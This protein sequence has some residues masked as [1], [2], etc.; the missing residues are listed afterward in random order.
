[1]FVST[2]RR[3]PL[4]MIALLVLVACGTNK[5]TI[6][7]RVIDAYTN[8]P[9]KDAALTF[10]KNGPVKTDAEGRYTTTAWSAKESVSIEAP[11]YETTSINLAEKPELAKTEP[12]TATLD[13]TIR[14]N[15]LRGVVKDAYTDQPVANAL[16]QATETISAT[17]DANGAYTLQSLPETFQIAV[18]APDYVETR[19]DISR[20]TTHELTLR[21]SV[22]RGIV[23]DT[24]SGQPVTGA[25]V[26]AGDISATTGSDG[27]YELKDVRE[28]AEVVFTADGYDE[29]KQ[30]MPQATSLDVA[31]RPNVI[32]G[33]VVDS[34]DGKPLA[35]ATVIATPTITGT[36]VAVTRTDAKGNYKLEDVPEGAYIRALLPGYRRGETQVKEG[37]LSPEIKLERFE[38]KA[39]YLKAN[40]ASN[41]METVNEYYDIIDQTELNSIVID[42]KSDNLADVGFIYYQSQV[43]EVL[44]AE[45]SADYMPI[46]E[47]LAE[48]KK[49][50]IYTI[51]RVHIFAHDNALLEKHPDWYVQKDGKPWFADF[52]IAWL[53]TYDE[54]VWDYNIKL[55]V[56][57][58][59]LGFDEIQFDYIRFPSDGDL[60]GAKFKGPRDWKNNPDEMFNTIGRF[61]ERAQKAINGAGAY[62]SVDVFGY[63]AWKPQANIGQNLQVMGKYADYV[64]PMVYPSHFVWGELGFENP[65]AHP[66]EIVD[67]SMQKVKDQLVGEAS[68]AKVRPWLQD[69]TLIWV[70]DQYIVR[71]GAKEVRAQIDAAEKNRANGV[72][73]WALWDSDNDYTA[74]ALKPQE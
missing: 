30:P 53:D 55:A 22:L 28:D 6:N 35:Q 15:T 2:V 37:G 65:G 33:T 39:L 3:V 62:F 29:V 49:R 19:A 63:V 60:T 50:N 36:A 57:V 72:D 54:R 68:R 23:K 71:Y 32:T 58:A 44:K 64:Y 14:P 61:M 17:T 31:L 27:A 40:V 45:T 66:Y 47:M 1:M 59:Q 4:L 13:V 41:G 51:A 5:V 20:K 74:E 18:Q 10:G 73:G 7:G 42:V 38:A 34:K 26:K 11:G 9:V 46:R 48:A 21:P 8:Q 25:T 69:F 43:P 67:F 70:P 16:V 12:T 56:E 52:G 24:Y